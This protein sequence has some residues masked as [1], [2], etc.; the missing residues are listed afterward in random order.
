MNSATPPVETSQI[1][2]TAKAPTTHHELSLGIHAALA[3]LP[4]GVLRADQIF[5]LS[6]RSGSPQVWRLA[7]DGGEAEQVTRLARDVEAFDVAP[8]GRKFMSNY[9]LGNEYVPATLPVTLLIDPVTGA[10]MHTWSGFVDA[11]RFMEDIIPFCDSTP[12]AGAVPH[13]R[14]KPAARPPAG[15]PRPAEEAPSPPVSVPR[16]APAA[17]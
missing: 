1:L 4:A 5:F 6:T 7:L 16:P 2:A 15:D 11:E 13:K 17:P 14:H 9:Q 10:K 12:S 3:K 8:D